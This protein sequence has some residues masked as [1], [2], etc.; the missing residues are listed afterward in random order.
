MATTKE[1]TTTTG[2]GV[3][4][5]SDMRGLFAVQKVVREM[6]LIVDRIGLRSDARLNRRKLSICGTPERTKA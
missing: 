3:R 5:I 4:H 1:L 2:V 6:P